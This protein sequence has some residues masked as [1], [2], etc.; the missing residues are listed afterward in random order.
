MSMFE[1]AGLS[2]EVDNAVEELKQIADFTT[3]SNDDSG[4]GHGIYKYIL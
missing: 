3:L 1:V 4:V 2:I